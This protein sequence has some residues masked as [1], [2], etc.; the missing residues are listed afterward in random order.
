MQQL[1]V[2]VFLVLRTAVPGGPPAHAW[3][4]LPCRAPDAVTVADRIDYLTT[5][6]SSTASDRARVRG[7]VG[8]PEVP[9]AR[10]TLVA[11]STI[12]AAAVQA[13]ARHRQENAVSTG[14]VVYDLDSAGFAVESPD[15]VVSPGEYRPLWLFDRTWAYLGTLAGI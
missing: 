1:M 6:L 13:L 14:W 11:D 9:N 2:A 12:C 8:L 5:L 7:S 10:V 15:L 3:F 4:G